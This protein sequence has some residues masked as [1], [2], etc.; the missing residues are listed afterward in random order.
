MPN[1]SE[2][3]T[4]KI[5]EL[6]ETTSLSGYIPVDSASTG[7]KKF[8]VSKLAL[9][10]AVNASITAVNTK[11][12]QNNAEIV[13]LK[14]RVTTIEGKI[15][16][17]LC[18]VG[19][20]TV[21]EIRAMQ[22]AN[23]PNGSVYSLS[24]EGRITYTMAGAEKYIDVEQYDEIAW[25]ETKGWNILGKDRRTDLSDY[26]K[27]SAFAS[28]AFSGDYS[29]LSNKPN[30]DLKADKSEMSVANV[31][32]DN[33]KKTIQL[34]SGLSQEVVVEHQDISGKANASDV[35]DAL[36]LKANTSDMET[37]LGLK[38]NASDVQTALGEKANASELTITAASR[39]AG[40][41]KKIIQLK[42]GVSTTVITEHQDIS[43][44]A[45][46]EDLSFSAGTDTDKVKIKLGAG[47]DKTQEVLKAHQDITGKAE[48][49]EMS[50]TAV[51]GD[52]TKKT[53]QLK[54]GL[55]QEV[56]VEHQNITGKADKS[57]MS[58]EAVQGD[59]TKKTITLKSGLS[60]EVLVE[61]Q[62][63]SGKADKS[64][65]SIEAVQGDSTKKTITLKSGVSQ[66]VLVAHQDI[67]GKANDA[68]LAAVAK[69]GNYSDLS[70]TP[71]IPKGYTTI[72]T[73]APTIANNVATYTVNPGEYAIL[74]K[75]QNVSANLSIKIVASTTNLANDQLLECGFELD[76]ENIG[77][78]LT[79]V[80][81]KGS[82]AVS[83]VVNLPSDLSLTEKLFGVFANDTVFIGEA[84]EST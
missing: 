82:N 3:A 31:Q 26:S 55:T 7:T 58:I 13:N 15:A 12:N 17:A 74:Q 64:E 50:V 39:A 29:D 19:E 24:D 35:A 76:I 5:R 65:M 60:Q 42:N 63:I 43:G 52:S 77:I 79:F 18:Y 22:I 27:T 41:D 36:A 40:D 47:N 67:S 45:N 62:N 10:S 78:Y 68:D 30:L 33:T 83:D 72:R 48:K 9:A 73:V 6:V 84:I 57:E 53:I 28:V 75:P 8:D 23:I 14:A 71:T 49:S 1:L 4:K 20:A 44:K 81:Y 69:S 61:H 16:G 59:T 56:V 37:A 11:A 46:S 51:Q 66:E 25:S 54:S 32:G 38:A 2:L 34:K 80:F 21:A 70:G